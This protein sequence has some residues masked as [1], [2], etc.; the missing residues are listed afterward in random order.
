MLE[1]A[2][3]VPSLSIVLL[4]LLTLFGTIDVLTLTEKYFS[5]FDVT[6]GVK[7]KYIFEVITRYCRIN[8]TPD[9]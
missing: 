7:K 9:F 3:P 2:P 1:T 8:R 5:T 6:L 4:T